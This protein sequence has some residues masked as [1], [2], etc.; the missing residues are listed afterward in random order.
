MLR[1][2]T[3][4]LPWQIVVL[5][6]CEK[7]PPPSGK[8]PQSSV[9]LTIVQGS[10]K[11]RGAGGGKDL[12]HG[13]GSG[14]ATPR[15]RPVLRPPQLS[16]RFFPFEA[17]QTDAVLSLDEDTSLSTSEVRPRPRAPRVLGWAVPMSLRPAGAAVIPS[18]RSL[19]R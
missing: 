6:S 7:P 1:E 5:W 10:R 2:P 16:Q 14:T 18:R 3:K 12:G 8:W 19:W 17:I 11:V 9:P 13:Q 15:H 4:P